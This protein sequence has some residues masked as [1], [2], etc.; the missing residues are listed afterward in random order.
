MVTHEVE[1]TGATPVADATS[2]EIEFQVQTFNIWILCNENFT[3]DPVS[4][5]FLIEHGFDFNKQYATGLPY[6]RGNDKVISLVTILLSFCV[7]EVFVLSGFLIAL[8]DL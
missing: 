2:K 4:V 3:V 6:Y 8:K 1:G 5:Q 7:S